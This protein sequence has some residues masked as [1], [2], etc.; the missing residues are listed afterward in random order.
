MMDKNYLYQKVSSIITE[1]KEGNKDEARYVS[2]LY[3]ITMYINQLFGQE[4]ERWLL[5]NIHR[6]IIQ[7]RNIPSCII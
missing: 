5:V 4:M 3:N 6:Y 1:T 2:E 7:L